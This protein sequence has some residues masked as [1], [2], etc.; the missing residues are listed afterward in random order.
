MTTALVC[1]ALKQCSVLL[2]CSQSNKLVGVNESKLN[3]GPHAPGMNEVNSRCGDSL[4]I[5]T[6]CLSPKNGFPRPL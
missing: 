1:S 4:R 2:H 3:L 6:W 5:I